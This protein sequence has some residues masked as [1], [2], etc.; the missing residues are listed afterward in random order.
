M[1]KK[2]RQNKLWCIHTMIDHES[3]T[4]KQEQ[5]MQYGK[6]FQNTSFLKVW[7]FVL[8]TTVSVAHR[9]MYIAPIDLQ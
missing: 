4:K 7:I 8:L 2:A 1:N 9:G 6:I 3:I 5:I